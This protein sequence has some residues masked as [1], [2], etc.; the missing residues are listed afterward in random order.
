MKKKTLKETIRTLE[1]R[2]NSYQTQ[3]HGLQIEN[4][5]LK[6]KSATELW[7]LKGFLEGIAENIE[8]AANDLLAEPGSL[9]VEILPIE[10]EFGYPL[11]GYRAIVAAESRG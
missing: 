3:V 9:K 8:K 11:F 7:S 5:A 6:E 4:K 10:N 1:N 2:L